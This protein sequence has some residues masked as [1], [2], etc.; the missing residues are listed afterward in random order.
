M[1][2]QKRPTV[3][4]DAFSRGGIQLEL[5]NMYA[6]DARQLPVWSGRVELLVEDL[7]DLLNRKMACV[8]LAGSEEKAAATLAE[9]LQKAV[10]GLVNIIVTVPPGFSSF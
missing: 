7:R 8:V 9:D 10:E 5:K 2:L 6:L 1:E 3:L 4:M